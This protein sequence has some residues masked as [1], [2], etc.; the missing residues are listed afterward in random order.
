MKRFVEEYIQ[1]RRRFGL[2]KAIVYIIDLVANRFFFF[3]CWSVIV[4]PRDEAAFP[5]GID[6]APLSSRFATRDDLIHLQQQGKWKI[7]TEKINLFNQG[8]RCLLSCVNNEIGGYTWAHLDGR[9]EVKPGLRLNIPAQYVYNYAGYTSPHFRGMKLQPYRHYM[10]LH[11]DELKSTAGLLGYV[12]YLNWSS[13]RGQQKSGYRSVGLMWL[14]KF[15]DDYHI[16]CSKK[17]RQFGISKV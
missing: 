8:D 4:L 17:V 2:A 6:G 3:D 10:L 12:K 15:R 9:P 1:I 5:E 11:Q 14:I 13:K 7:D 16:Y